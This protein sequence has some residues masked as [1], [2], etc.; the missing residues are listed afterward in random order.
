MQT[1]KLICKSTSEK[2]HS[3][4]IVVGEKNATIIGYWKKGQKDEGDRAKSSKADHL[5]YTGFSL[6]TD[7][8]QNGRMVVDK[9][10][11]K[12]GHGTVILQN[13]YC[14]DGCQVR[15]DILACKVSN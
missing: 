2:S 10:L 7:D 9:K 4:G 1:Y 12:I 13:D 8:G 3:F 15:E 11:L 5:Y 6:Y 14:E